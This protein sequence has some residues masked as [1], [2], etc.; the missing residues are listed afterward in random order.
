MLREWYLF[1]QNDQQEQSKENWTQNSAKLQQVGKH[2][3]A[4]FRCQFSEKM[5]RRSTRLGGMTCLRYWTKKKYLHVTLQGKYSCSSSD[6][7]HFDGSATGYKSKLETHALFVHVEGIVCKCP[8]SQDICY[9]KQLLPEWMQIHHR[10]TVRQLQ[11]P[12]ARGFKV[13]WIPKHVTCLD[14]REL[15]RNAW[16][17]NICLNPDIWADKS[18]PAMRV[19]VCLSIHGPPWKRNML[20]GQLW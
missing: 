14:T 16:W 6:C 18:Q 7:M 3:A 17:R 2:N 4:K 15:K 20:S 11:P 9:T 13:S 1:S 19:C 8:W 12:L 5:K 10:S